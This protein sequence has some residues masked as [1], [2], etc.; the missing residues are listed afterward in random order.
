[1]QKKRQP[2]YGRLRDELSRL[3]QNAGYEQNELLDFINT[4]ERETNEPGEFAE[5]QAENERLKKEVMRLRNLIQAKME[6]SMSSK[7]REALRE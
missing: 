1:M 7:L 3:F 6:S 2:D 4:A 5:L